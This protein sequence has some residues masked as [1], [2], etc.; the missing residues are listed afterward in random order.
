MYSFIFSLILAASVYAVPQL[1]PK[2]SELRLI[3]T[4][5]NTQPKWMTEQQIF[6]LYKSN[7]K[8]MDITWT[9]DL[10]NRQNFVQEKASFPAKPTQQAIVKPIIE[11]ASTDLMK[12]VLPPFTQFNNRYYRSETGKQSSK[13]LQ[14]RI[15]KLVSESSIGSKK[16]SVNPFAH[17]WGQESIIARIEGK[18]SSAP[19]VIVGAHQD[20]INQMSPSSGRAPGADDDGSGSVTILEAFRLLIN[21]DFEL[22]IPVEF[23]W[24]S[25]EEAGLLGSQAIADAYKKEGRQVAGMMQLDMTGYPNPSKKDIGI[26]T[27]YTDKGLTALVREMVNDYTPL[28]SG[29]F[30]CGYGCSDHASWNEAGYPSVIP[31]E[32]SNMHANRNIHTTRDTLETIDYDHALNFAKLAVGYV[33][34]LAH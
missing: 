7:T 26:V 23:Q 14:E 30:K 3:K 31:F 5:P 13:W 27:D 10:G 8:F 2:D 25:G 34:E 24:Y 29:D 9:K 32:S 1:I 15:K 21:S 12:N 17:S 20:S 33:V 28:K 18:D 6:D 19:T 4:G 11:K 22:N 16:I